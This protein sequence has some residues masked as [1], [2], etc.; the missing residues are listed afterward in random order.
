LAKS[1]LGHVHDNNALQRW[2]RASYCGASPRRSLVS[3]TFEKL[4]VIQEFVEIEKFIDARVH[5]DGN[6][7]L[8]NAKGV[9]DAI[10]DNTTT[11]TLALVETAVVEGIGSSS[12]S[13]AQSVSATQGWHTHMG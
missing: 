11:Q 4:V 7:S 10:G 13:F 8:G 12:S 9:A 2:P 5:V 3:L 1:R 6:S